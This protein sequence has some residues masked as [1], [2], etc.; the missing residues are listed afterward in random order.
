M[1]DEPWVHLVLYT[2]EIPQNTGNVGRLALGLDCRLHLVRPLAFD[3]DAKAVRRAGLDYWKHV[4]LQVHEDAHAFWAWASGR[5]VHAFSA[6]GERC[7]PDVRFTWGDV[8]LFGRESTGLPAEVVAGHG[9]GVRLP[10]IGPIRSLNLANAA[11]VAAYA[12]LSQ[13]RPDVR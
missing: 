11:S 1:A 13:V 4:D 6:R 8:L 7:L 5:R 9:G 3:I 12:A 2:P 10:M